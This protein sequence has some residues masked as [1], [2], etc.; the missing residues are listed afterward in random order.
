MKNRYL[1]WRVLALFAMPVLL[2]IIVIALSCAPINLKNTEEVLKFYNLEILPQA[3]EMLVGEILAGAAKVKIT[4]TFE[5]GQKYKIAGYYKM[6]MNW[7]TV[8][9]ESQVHDDLWAR[10][11]YLN[12]GVWPMAI[13]SFDLIGMEGSDIK[14]IQER[15][16]DIVYPWH[17]FLTFTHTH[18]G[19]DTMGIWGTIPLISGKNK[20]YVEQ[21]KQ[22]AEICL[23][24]A[25]DSVK[26]AKISFGQ[27]QKNNEKL[28]LLIHIEDRNGATIASIINYAIHPHLIHGNYVSADIIW[29]LYHEAFEDKVGGTVI[30]VNGAQG[31][32]GVLIEH[33]DG[34][35]N[36]DWETMRLNGGLLGNMAMRAFE[37]REAE[38]NPQFMIRYRKIKVTMDNWMFKFGTFWGTLTERRDSEGKIT[39]EVSRI[40]IGENAEIITIPG[41]AMPNIAEELR[42]LMKSKYKFVFGLT[43]DELGYII[44]KEDWE[45]EK[46]PYQMHVSIGPEIGEIIFENL[47]DLIER[48]D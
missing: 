24:Q 40:A 41:E 47:K 8:D 37:Q 6:G 36:N 28:M 20:E 42:G 33:A 30:F 15:I 34:K 44:R 21:V 48:R 4:P 11:A 29:P 31:G 9:N 38:N 10:C 22:K 25:R 3:N 46:H 1:L 14:D 27:Y 35:K 12:D 16:S 13:I 19:P 2:I 18:A 45:A 5:K 26:P 43:N 7:R 32:V 39:T 23:R 17:N